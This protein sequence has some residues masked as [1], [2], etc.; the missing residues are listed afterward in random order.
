MSLNTCLFNNFA[1][2]K[3]EDFTFCCTIVEL[4]LSA[5]CLSNNN[6]FLRFLLF[7]IV[8]ISKLH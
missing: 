1:Y 5:P 6:D 8:K 3:I 2:L 7:S 4:P